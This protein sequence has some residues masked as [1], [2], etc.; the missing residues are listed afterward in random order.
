MAAK[1][2]VCEAAGRKWGGLIDLKY[3]W[4]TSPLFDRSIGMPAR[5]NVL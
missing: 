3:T 4:Y 1:S 5:T 2:P